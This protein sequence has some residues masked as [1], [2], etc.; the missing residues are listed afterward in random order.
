M[1]RKKTKDNITI[2]V[3]KKLNNIIDDTIA[4][5]SK[6]VEWLIYQD[7]LK[8]SKDERIKEVIV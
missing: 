4:N 2:S 3:D 7:L 8:N 1:K 5:R 6:Y